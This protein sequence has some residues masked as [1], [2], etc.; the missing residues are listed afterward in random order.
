MQFFYYEK[1]IIAARCSEALQFFAVLKY[2]VCEK[3]YNMKRKLQYA[4]SYRNCLQCMFWQY[5]RNLL[6]LLYLRPMYIYLSLRERYIYIAGDRKGEVA[7]IAE[8]KKHDSGKLRLDLLPPEVIRGLGEVLT[9]GAAKYGPDQWR[10]V[11]PSRYKAALLRHYL[12]MAEGEAVD[13]ESG[14][15]HAKHLLCNAAFL[16]AL[17]ENK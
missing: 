13:A 2:G 6:K 5:S 14:L 3:I 9:F 1:Q 8:G 15:S 7:G 4:A 11:E 12:A 10:G 16:V 17:E